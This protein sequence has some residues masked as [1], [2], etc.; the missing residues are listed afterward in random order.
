MPTSGD[1]TQGFVTPSFQGGGAVDPITGVPLQFLTPTTATPGFVSGGGGQ[2]QQPTGGGG[3]DPLSV[4]SSVGKLKKITDFGSTA[5]SSLLGTGATSGLASG[6]S[7]AGATSG[8]ASGVSFGAGTTS[9]LASGIG[10]SHAAATGASTAGAGIGLGAVALPL[11]A[12]IAVP[13]IIGMFT[14]Q[15]SDIAEFKSDIGTNNL[16]E[17]T[18]Y[19]SKNIGTEQAETYSDLL[20]G[21]I[22]GVSSSL[23]L[24]LEGA[25]VF[26]GYH[27]KK[28]SFLRTDYTAGIDE[29]Q[30]NFDPANEESVTKALF[31]MTFNLAERQAGE[32]GLDDRTRKM[33]D[34]YRSMDLTGKDAN[35]IVAELTGQ[36]ITGAAG[37]IR[38]QETRFLIPEAKRTGQTFEEFKQGFI[39]ERDANTIQ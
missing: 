1:F 29:D 27:S 12:A 10:F 3:I 2:P 22:G 7:L 19:G 25:K 23:N 28:G 30:Y 34:Q 20:S 11:A 16:F 39:E 8:L 24:N 35:A 13:M 9:G 21:F 5:I 18:T 32:G 31:D 4:L 14:G 37:G 33:I 17:N 38:A 15:S 36:P 26:G 6:V